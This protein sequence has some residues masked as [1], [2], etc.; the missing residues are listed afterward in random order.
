VCEYSKTEWL[1]GLQHDTNPLQLQPSSLKPG[2]G[3]GRLSWVQ[4]C[5]HGASGRTA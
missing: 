4:V 3:F 5:T 2:D 1:G